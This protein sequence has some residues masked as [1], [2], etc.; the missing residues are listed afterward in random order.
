MSDNKRAAERY[1]LPTLTAEVD[2]MECVL[3]NVS[4]TGVLLGD[5]AN[6]FALGEPITVYIFI[7]LKHGMTNLK[8]KGTVARSDGV[9]IGVNY[10]TPT[11][12]WDRLLKVLSTL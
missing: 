11:R 12:T 2:G 4:S 10:K 3:L 1:E 6:K 8:I 5:L 9:S 7:P